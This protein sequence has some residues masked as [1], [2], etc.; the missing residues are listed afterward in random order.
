[1]LSCLA[2]LLHSRYL[3]T[4]R[5]TNFLKCVFLFVN[6]LFVPFFFFCDH[7]FTYFL[8]IVLIFLLLSMFALSFYVCSTF[9][10]PRVVFSSLNN[11]TFFF[12][13]ITFLWPM[14]MFIYLKK[15]SNSYNSIYIKI[16]CELR[17][18]VMINWLVLLDQLRLNTEFDS[19]RVPLTF[20]LL[21]HLSYA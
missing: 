1:M 21:S 19:H 6:A 15:K 5:N 18:G 20:N 12:A 9:P 8:K 10:I 16:Q 13:V 3:C 17:R 11:F 14:A 7:F 2:N 4:I